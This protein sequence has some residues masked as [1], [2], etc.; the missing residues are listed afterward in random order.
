MAKQALN[1]S[2]GIWIRVSTE[3]QARGESPAHHEKRARLYAEAKGWDVF[4][5]YDLSGV[6][7]KSV[8]QH[9]EAKRMLKDVHTR[10][11]SGLIFS[12]LARLAR[13]TK[14]LLEFSEIFR[15]DGADLISL[16]ESIDTSSPAGRL[17]YTMIAAM[18]Q[19]ERE[20]ISERISASVPIRAKMGKPI[21]GQPSLGYH[22]VDK[23]LVPHPEEAPVRK[24]IY[25]LFIEHQRKKT[26]AKI[27]NE[28]GYRTRNGAKFSDTTITRL[29]RDPTAKG[30]HRANYTRSMG[31]GKAAALKAEADW[32]LR[33]VPAIVSPGQ[34][35]E[36]NAILDKQAFGGRKFK[37]GEYLFSGLLFCACG[38]K[39]YVKSPLPKYVCRACNRKMPT[40]D[41]EEV[42]RHEL[43]SFF[44]SE[45]DI[46]AFLEKDDQEIGAKEEQVRVLENERRKGVSEMDRI[47]RAFI[48]ESLPAKTFGELH[49][50]L[51]VRQEE[52]DDE[53]AKLSAE[54]DLRK[55]NHLSN[56]EV[57][58]SARD[59]YGRWASLSF[60]EKRAIVEA[61][62]EDITI[63]ETIEINLSY[64]P[65]AAG[66]GGGSGPPDNSF[67]TDGQKATR[68][69][70]FIAAASK[71]R[72][73]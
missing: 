66:G 64:M 52:I 62:V 56:E 5:L 58:A 14:E 71:M 24:L 19:W 67:G 18:A 46:R 69:H 45:A 57:V 51:K 53:V 1:K 28:R 34:W 7:G 11:I 36:A 12:K 21:G 42:F 30:V 47:Y 20:E 54:V 50:K 61:I 2:V 3:D 70:G 32:V 68:Q 16:Q 55:I 17:F 35:A 43:H 38:Q 72:A 22:W 41:L 15:E 48:G 6:S 65:P 4:T 33:E 37:R 59:L 31:R 10:K 40:D 25:D 44:L 13:N 27:L 39:M 29:L 60:E 8:M 73:G 23:K 26:V 9:P 63:G 49:G